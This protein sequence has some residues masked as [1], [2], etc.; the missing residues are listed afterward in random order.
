MLFLACFIN[1]LRELCFAEEGLEPT[2]YF[3]TPK[4]T[5]CVEMVLTGNVLI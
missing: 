5:G 1:F 3:T 4:A 2:N